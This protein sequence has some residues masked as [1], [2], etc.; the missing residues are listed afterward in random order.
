LPLALVITVALGYAANNATVVDAGDSVGIRASLLESFAQSSKLSTGTRWTVAAF[1]VAALLWASIAAARAIRAAH[2][3]AWQGRVEQFTK[4]IHAA[5]VLIAALLAL[6]LVWSA[7]GWAREHLGLLPGLVV[8]FAAVVPFFAIWLGIASL[9]PHDEAPWRALVPGALLVAAG[10]QIIHLG[11][12]L[13]LTDRVERASATY[14][15]FGAALTILVWLYVISR[16][17]VGSAMLNATLWQ[18]RAVRATSTTS[19]TADSR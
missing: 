1:G 10:L 9:L 18:R 2:A 13:F 5:L 15:S 6:A 17:I 11:T 7:V 12:V 16:L 14:G 8:A 19:A 3:L 4:P